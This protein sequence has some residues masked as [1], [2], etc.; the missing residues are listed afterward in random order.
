MDIVFSASEHRYPL[1]IQHSYWKWSFIV[2]FPIRKNVTFHPLSCLFTRG[3]GMMKANICWWLPRLQFCAEKHLGKFLQHEP[4]WNRRIFERGTSNVTLEFPCKVSLCCT[5]FQHAV[6]RKSP[7]NLYLPNVSEYCKHYFL[8]FRKN[9]PQ[10]TPVFWGKK[11]GFM[12]IF[13]L[14]QSID[15]CLA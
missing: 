15:W 7:K 14:K 5:F 3:K 12:H 9:W 13:P 4:S 8:G 10:E 2:S 1:V 11:L 6:R